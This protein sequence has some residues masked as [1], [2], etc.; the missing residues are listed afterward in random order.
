MKEVGSSAERNAGPLVIIGPSGAGKSTIVTA[1]VAQSVVRIV[2]TWTDRPPRPGEADAG[3]TGEH[4]F[5]TADELTRRSE[6]GYFL[7]PPITMFGLPYRYALPKIAPIDT[8][9][10][11]CVMLRAPLRPLAGKYFPNAI[12][13]AVEAPRQRI[14][15]VL[16]E[17]SLT[18]AEQGS[19][20]AD[21]DAEITAGRDW[22]DRIISNDD[23]AAAI[24][25]VT[26]AISIDFKHKRVDTSG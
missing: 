11:D 1:L 13:Y 3:Q 6:A 19:R 23:L 20:L 12:V 2:P 7:H 22:A 14:A 5:V 8:M 21:Y 16:A 25:A 18:G 26:E 15:A 24:E 17:R 4:I 10:V 9:T